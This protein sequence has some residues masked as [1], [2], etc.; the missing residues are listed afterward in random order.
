MCAYNYINLPALTR[1]AASH[2]LWWQWT[3]HRAKTRFVKLRQTAT[4][5]LSKYAS[6]SRTSKKK[7]IIHFIG[8]DKKKT[9]QQHPINSYRK[10]KT[11]GISYPSIHPSHNNPTSL[12]YG[13]VQDSPVRKEEDI[14]D[15]VL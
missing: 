11:N 6:E 8:H 15:R 1:A 9:S 13:A 4:Q 10:Y 2:G 5:V 12:S 7:E 14:L 3:S